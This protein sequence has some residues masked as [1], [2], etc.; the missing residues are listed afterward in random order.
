MDVDGISQVGI[1]HTYGTGKVVGTV[2]GF[3]INLGIHGEIRNAIHQGILFGDMGR[4]I[5]PVYRI[6]GT[7][8]F[9]VF[10]GTGK[11]QK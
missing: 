9:L 1:A 3:T 7:N 6:D 5:A 10:F 8:F 2:F 11:N 4:A